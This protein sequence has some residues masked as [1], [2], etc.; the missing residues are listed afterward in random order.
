[1]PHPITRALLSAIHHSSE[2]MVL[3]DPYAPDHP[4]MAANAAF[5]TM[6]GYSMDQV[7]GRNCRFLQGAD[8][9]PATTRRIA[10]SI[11]AQQ[12]CIEWVVNHKAN[13]RSF[14]NLLFLFPVHDRAGHLMHYFGNQLD[15][16]AGLPDWLAEVSFG[17]AHMSEANRQE[18]QTL[19]LDIME[20]EDTAAAEPGARSRAL[21]RIVATTRR[22]AELSTDL[23][24]GPPM[25]VPAPSH[26]NP[27]PP[28]PSRSSPSR[29]S[30]AAQ[31]ARP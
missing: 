11:R 19:L 24:P 3:S 27:S 18:F 2:P 16:T 5:M 9:D 13:G 29:P 4:I 21:E 8:T 26:L 20:S 28:R 15:I 31:A 14:W 25:P 22:L 17:R 1:M 6:T 7:V 30:P 23:T 10:A 12:A